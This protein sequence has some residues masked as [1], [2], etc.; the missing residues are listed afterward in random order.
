MFSGPACSA[1]G[2]ERN[3]ALGVDEALMG[4]ESS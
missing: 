1:E 4:R 2:G 3:E